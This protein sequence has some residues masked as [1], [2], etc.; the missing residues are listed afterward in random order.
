[1]MFAQPK[2][3]KTDLK[4]EELLCFE[5]SHVRQDFV[6]LLEEFELFLISCFWPTCVVCLNLHF[7]V[8]PT[9]P[10]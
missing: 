9:L 1:M 3:D 8:Y 2:S 7:F 6:M 5:Q 10:R 4:I